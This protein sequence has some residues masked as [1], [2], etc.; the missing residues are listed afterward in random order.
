MGLMG[1]EAGA[2]SLRYE[3]R[4]GGRILVPVSINGKGPYMLLFDTG[5]D[6]TVL[7][8]RL[9]RKLGLGTSGKASMRTFAGK[10]EV[11]LARVERLS[12]GSR[13]DGPVGVVCADLAEMFGLPGDIQGILGQDFLAQFSFLLV[14]KERRLEIDENGSL[15]EPPGGTRLMVERKG[16]RYYV[17]G[18]L[19][20]ASEPR[21]L[22]LDSGIPY[23]LLYEDPLLEL[24]CS[25]SN[26]AA[27]SSIGAR[28]LR[29]CRLK[30]LDLGAV[31]FKNLAVQLTSRLAGPRWEDGILP[32]GLFDAIYFNNAGSFVILNP[33]T[34]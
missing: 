29:S 11:P 31:Q 21:R 19:A 7:D 24:R 22:L 25:G 13:S 8:A 3:V 17:S 4:E 5:A 15:A 14:R 1:R 34:R 26:G 9:A 33:S 20:G 10:V 23:S 30:T 28:K 32:L 6:T 2:A 12:L 18:L 27:E 16:G